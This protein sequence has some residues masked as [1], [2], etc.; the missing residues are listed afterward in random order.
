MDL[1]NLKVTESEQLELD[2]LLSQNNIAR[3]TLHFRLENGL[4][5]AELAQIAQ[6][7]QARVSEIESL[8][9]DPRLSTLGRI[10]R[11]L[12]CMIDMVPISP[13]STAATAGVY[14]TVSAGTPDL[15]MIAGESRMNLVS[16]SQTTMVDPHSPLYA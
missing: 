12:G 13:A 2:A 4:T 3:Q 8:K 5:Q 10:A 1:L 11:A 6:T 9:G 16:L 14:R 7:T 15:V